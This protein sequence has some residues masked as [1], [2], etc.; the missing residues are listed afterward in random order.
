VDLFWTGLRDIC[1]TD[2]QSE[3]NSIHD[4]ITYWPWIR[5]VFRSEIVILLSMLAIAEGGTGLTGYLEAY[6]F[7]KVGQWYNFTLSELLPRR[8]QI[9]NSPTNP[10]WRISLVGP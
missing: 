1:F 6:I 5:L 9:G 4:L 8:R 7:L 2:V 10:S 3:Q